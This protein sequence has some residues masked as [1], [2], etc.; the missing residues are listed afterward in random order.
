MVHP[1]EPLPTTL[2]VSPKLLLVGIV[3]V[4]NVLLSATYPLAAAR[5]AEPPV[6][7]FHEN[8]PLG[9]DQEGGEPVVA[10]KT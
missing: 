2:I 5:V 4:V 8:P 9:E 6:T 10:V 7:S 1:P 3:K